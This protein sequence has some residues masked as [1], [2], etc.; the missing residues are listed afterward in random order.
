VVEVGGR[1]KGKADGEVLR[2]REEKKPETVNSLGR[3]T[4]GGGKQKFHVE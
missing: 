1:G 2:R 4:I 3:D